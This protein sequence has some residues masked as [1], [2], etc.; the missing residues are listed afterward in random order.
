MFGQFGGIA[1]IIL[2]LSIGLLPE[3]VVVL[4]LGLVFGGP[5]VSPLAVLPP[6]L[7]ILCDLPQLLQLL[8]ELIAL[9]LARWLE[10]AFL[11]LFAQLLYA[12]LGLGGL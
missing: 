11:P 8:H 2:I 1:L 3:E 10:A 7:L 4:F 5:A 6:D 12:V 9:G